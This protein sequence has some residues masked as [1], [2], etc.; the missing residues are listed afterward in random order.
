MLI[1]KATADKARGRCYQLGLTSSLMYTHTHTHTHTH[2][3]CLDGSAESEFWLR[4]RRQ[5]TVGETAK[6]GT[7]MTL[8]G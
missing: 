3:G 7:G 1:P 5:P 2:S 6:K 4:F 8:V